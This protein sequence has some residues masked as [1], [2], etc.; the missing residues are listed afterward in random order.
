[1]DENIKSQK[2]L[3]IED[4]VN[5]GNPYCVDVDNKIHYVYSWQQQIL[6]CE[7]KQFCPYK[8][9]DKEQILCDYYSYDNIMERVNEE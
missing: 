3:T 9:Q 8:K 5:T 1:M 4:I 7:Y 6:L 2:E